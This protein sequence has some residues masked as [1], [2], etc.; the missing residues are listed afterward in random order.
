MNDDKAEELAD[1][2]DG[3]TIQGWTLRRFLGNG[4]SAVV[5]EAEKSDTVA[6]LKVFDPDLI[7]SFGEDV[8]LGRIDRELGL[9]DCNKI[10]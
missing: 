6:A 1:R 9:R 5:F 3:R 4:K 8:Q 10:T 2:L 7:T